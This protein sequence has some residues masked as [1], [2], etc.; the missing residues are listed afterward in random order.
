MHSTNSIKTMPTNQFDIAIIGA[1]AAG[2]HLALA[3]RNDAFF[4]TKNI[5]ILEKDAKEANDRTWCF[6]E[7][8]AGKWDHLLLKS[9]S[10]GDFF[11]KTNHRPLDLLP[12]RYK[13]LRGA[14][15]YRFA[16]SELA[17]APNF[18][19]VNDEISAVENLS[20]KGKAGSYEADLVFDSRL[21]SAISNLQF[22]SSNNSLLQHF[23][24][25][26]VRTPEPRFD[27]ERFTMM[28]YRIRWQDTSSFTYVLPINERE[29]L[30]EFTLFNDRLIAQQD[31]DSMLR[32]Y[33]D[34]VLNIKDFQILEEE[35]GVIPM[36]DYRFDKHSTG[37]HIRIGTA[38][39]WM[40]GSSGYTFKNC[41]RYSQRI[42]ENMKARRP[43]NEGVFSPKFHF[44]D[45]IFLGVLH[46]QNSLGPG[47]FEEMYAKNKVQDI[48]AFLDN[49]SSFGTDLSI[50][51]KF[52]KWPFIQSFFRLLSKNIGHA[53]RH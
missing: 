18:T 4:D 49:E 26:Y 11:G 46:H 6:W 22:P 34:K 21:P 10:K 47:V 15:F 7:K 25:W 2:L 41:E 13:M 50:I 29:A 12:Y 24:G 40:K 17:A 9:W 45:S 51:L 14:D 8:G 3:M 31:Y 32:Q 5:L 48:F 20:I 44:Y 33:F 42:V 19:W 36:T 53:P 52:K 35:Y 1:G 30:V 23:K 43:A 38:G 27:A 37:N 28:D 16:K 39:G